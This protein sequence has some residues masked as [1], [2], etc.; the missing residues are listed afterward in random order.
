MWLKEE[1]AD[2]PDDY[3]LILHQWKGQDE[4]RKS[5]VSTSAV[6]ERRKKLPPQNLRK[7]LLPSLEVERADSVDKDSGSTLSESLLEIPITN[8]IN[9]NKPDISSVSSR[10]STSVV[11]NAVNLLIANEIN[12]QVSAIFNA[13]YAANCHPLTNND[14]IE[15]ARPDLVSTVAQQVANANAPKANE[16]DANNTDNSGIS[17]SAGQAIKETLSS[18]LGRTAQLN[19]EN[20]P[21]PF[22]HQDHIWHL[23]EH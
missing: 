23:P 22:P 3:Y 8:L 16:G 1:S 2:H 21:P 19:N 10:S 11:I 15:A 20:P 6:V 7:R 14:T 17:N 9:S 5:E 4:Q 13:D 18:W 12:K